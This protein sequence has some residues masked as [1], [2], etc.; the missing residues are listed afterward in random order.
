MNYRKKFVVEPGEKIHL[1]K[2]DPSYTGQHESHEKAMPIMQEHIARMDKL[3][4]LLYADG[5][6]SLLIVLQ[7]LDA[8]GKDGVVRHV[9]SGMN[10]QGT[11]VF[12]FKQPSKDEAAH[13]FLW[14][15]HQ[16]APARG[17]VVIFNRSHYE[18]VLVVRVHKLAKKS[19]WSKRYDL[20]NDFEK[21][22]TCNGTRILK[23][24]LHISPEEQLARFKQRLDDP[25]RH[26]KISDADYSERELWSKYTEAYEDVLE[27]TS[28][29]HAPWYV[30]PSNHKWFR[31][32]A[33]SQIIADTMDE[34][35]LKLPPT[36][37][38]IDTITKQFHA[39][40]QK[41][42]KLVGKERGD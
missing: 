29:P 7:A 40:E 16:R 24:F 9:F 5:D 30:I 39:A 36:H 23:F 19:I 15:A 3:Q 41:Q 32:L 35:G 28:T 34:M 14:R 42:A 38:D 27:L 21:M 1:N 11:S 13:D 31:N 22:L 17:E 4:Y 6:Q 25:S 26:W 18:D 20:I 2:V 33:I 12:G 8:A 10:P 37:V